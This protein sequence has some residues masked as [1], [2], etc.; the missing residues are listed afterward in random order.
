MSETTLHDQ[1]L[2]FTPEQ[3]QEIDRCLL[4]L[5]DHTGSPLVMIADVSG[6]LVLYRGRL[7][8]AQ[9]T[10][11]SALAAGGFAAGLGIGHF[12]GLRDQNSFNCQLLEGDL[13][14]LYIMA[15][16]PELLLI[17]AFTQQTTLGMVRLFSE[18]AQQ[19]LLLLAEAA[20]KA[21]EEAAA[22][23]ATRPE[24]GFGEE[25]SRQLDELFDGGF[26]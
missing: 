20:S 26:E 10:G 18:Q 12:L 5:A 1:P 6:R 17:T 14:N 7:S 13:A 11:L 24:D 22:E 9:S 25:V 3:T 21:R 2:S 4:R 19:E 8:E 15:I 16:G 23:A